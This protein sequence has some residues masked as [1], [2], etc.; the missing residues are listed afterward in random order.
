MNGL[1]QC[2][3]LG[4]GRA[5]ATPDFPAYVALTE[6][7]LRIGLTV[8]FDAVCELEIFYRL[9]PV[10]L[11]LPAGITCVL[12]GCFGSTLVVR[13]SLRFFRASYLLC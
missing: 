9:Q 4:C 2:S 5:L 6:Q 11:A 7:V 12:R 1:D 3:S 10:M 8:F 13:D